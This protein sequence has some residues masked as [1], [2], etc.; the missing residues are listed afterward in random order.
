MK[1]KWKLDPQEVTWRGYSTSS[2]HRT[3]ATKASRSVGLSSTAL[4][5]VH[6]PTGLEIEGRIPE[7]HY[8]RRK[9]RELKELLYRDL[10][11][12]LEDKVAKHLRIPGK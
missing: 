1:E 8:S 12:K 7:G 4:T 2:G 11:D 9:L 10:F 3:H 5:L 6:M